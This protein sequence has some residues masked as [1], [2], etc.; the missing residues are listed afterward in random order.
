MIFYQ[1]CLGIILLGSV[2]CCN[3]IDGK[4]LGILCWFILSIMPFVYKYDKKQK[5]K[6]TQEDIYKI[7]Q[8]RIYQEKYYNEFGE[9]P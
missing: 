4:I 3:G 5:R 2:Y 7:N 8:Q 6:L 1:I 9:L